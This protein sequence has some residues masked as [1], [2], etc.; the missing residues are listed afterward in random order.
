MGSDYSVSLILYDTEDNPINMIVNTMSFKIK[1]EIKSLSSRGVPDESAIN[2]IWKCLGDTGSCF[3]FESES[4]TGILQGRMSKE[5]KEIVPPIFEL[6]IYG[7]ENYP[8][9][10]RQG[11]MWTN[12]EAGLQY[13]IACPTRI[14]YKADGTKPLY[15]TST[16]IVEFDDKKIYP[17]WELHSPNDVEILSL[18]E[19][20]ISVYS[21]DFSGSNALTAEIKTVYALSCNK[22]ENLAWPW[23]DEYLTYH[24]YLEAKIVP[25][26][27]SVYVPIVFT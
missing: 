7:L 19:S 4:S 20:K 14:E 13:S 11:F 6:T 18:K 17:E 1:P 8:I 12:Q 22:Q 16:F 26:N 24:Y 21:S 2:Y 5:L 25:D 27:I 3:V 10:V 15:D 23:N 9:V